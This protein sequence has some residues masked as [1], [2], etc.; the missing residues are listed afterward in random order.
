LLIE[1]GANLN[2][3]N[4]RGETALMLATG[5]G[6]E[7]VIKLLIDK[8]ADPQLKN[9]AGETAMNYANRR[10]NSSVSA[11][12]EAKGVKPE[13]PV[14]KEK[15]VVIALLGTWQGSK[16]GMGQITIRLALNK[17]N[18]YDFVVKLKPEALKQFP[19]GSM[20]P[21]VATHKGT[22]TTES[23]TLILY[24]E[25]QAPVAMKWSLANGVLVL[26]GNTRLKK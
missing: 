11:L 20:N 14:V 25:G 10:G 4:K 17:N 19:A 6:N 7:K 26:D 22:Y 21:V 24:P 16:D 13:A 15:V 3:V 18:T 23:D 5:A 1:R 8:G 2:A 12:L 9:L